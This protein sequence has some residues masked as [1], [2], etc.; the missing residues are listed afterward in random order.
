MHFP[1]PK[2]CESGKIW[3]EAGHDCN[4]NCGDNYDCS[5]ATQVPGCFCPDGMKFDGYECVAPTECPCPRY[6]NGEWVHYPIGAYYMANRCEMWYVALS[7][8]MLSGHC[9]T[10]HC[11]HALHSAKSINTMF[12]GKI[13]KINNLD[14]TQI[15]LNIENVIVNQEQI[16]LQ[17]DLFVQETLMSQ[18]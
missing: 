2:P 18:W 12:P 4:E 9:N 3:K 7:C 8:L 14:L 10:W 15:V 6:E 1:A 17:S 11:T 13:I 5:A 16:V